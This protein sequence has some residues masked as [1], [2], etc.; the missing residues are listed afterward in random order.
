MNLIDAARAAVAHA[1]VLSVDPALAA[2]CARMAAELR[3]A[4]LNVEVYGGDDKLGKQL[5]YADRSKIPLAVIYGSREKDAGVVK[6]KDLR[7]AAVTRE[8]DV[9]RADL[10]L[11]IKQLVG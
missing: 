5:K 8:H 6:L 2:D 10:V 9:P 4:G 1:L 7:E 3:D 11:R